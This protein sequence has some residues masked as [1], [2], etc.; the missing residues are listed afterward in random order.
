MGRNKSEGPRQQDKGNDLAL[1]A[2]RRSRE[3]I[4]APD[5]EV[6]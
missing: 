1:L 5:I 4:P 6:N 2:K 3:A